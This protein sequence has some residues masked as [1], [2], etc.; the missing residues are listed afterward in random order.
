LSSLIK[1]FLASLSIIPR[2]SIK[3][4]SH[5]HLL[6]H[7]WNQS[8][9]LNKA[10]FS[11]IRFFL[12][13]SHI[14][15][16]LSLSLSLSLAEMMMLGL[17]F[18]QLFNIRSILAVCPSNCS[19][20]SIQYP[21]GTDGCGRSGFKLKCDKSYR[22]PKLFL[23]NTSIE[24]LDISYSNSIILVR[25][26]VVNTTKLN[27]ND[28]WSV[29]PTNGPYVFSTIRNKFVAVG[30]GMLA[31]LSSL[32]QPQQVVSACA[33]VCASQGSIPTDGSCTGIG[34]CKSSVP[35]SLGSFEFQFTPLDQIPFFANNFSIKAFIVEET[36]LNTN[37]SVMGSL[38][39]NITNDQSAVVPASVDWKIDGTSCANAKG[40]SDYECK[41]DNSVCIDY[42]GT[43]YQCQCSD[44]F[45]GNPYVTNGCQG[46]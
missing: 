29:L 10:L 4:S 43:G 22:P 25:T 30:C 23:E 20:I 6:I 31:Q 42:Y 37:F 2:R 11:L 3:L 8:L 35:I 14:T 7:V 5:F 24:V 28:S 36:W 27:Y 9:F 16:S 32:G 15:L 41:S 33:S 39:G 45:D 13:P 12:S 21:F 34:C 38:Y 46:M 44:G 26:K 40:K 17:L 19:T 18:L 1:T